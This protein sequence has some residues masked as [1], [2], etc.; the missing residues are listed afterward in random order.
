[1]IDGCA[2]ARSGFVSIGIVIVFD[3]ISI[4]KMDPD[5]YVALFKKS[6][7]DRFDNFYIKV[8]RQYRNPHQFAIA[9]SR[10]SFEFFIYAYSFRGV[11]PEFKLVL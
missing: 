7:A 10:T 6:F 9:S 4:I 5:L 8:S 3:S 2:I 1:M 11:A